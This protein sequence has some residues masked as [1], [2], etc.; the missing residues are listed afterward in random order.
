M[1]L[2]WVVS[3]HLDM[4]SLEQCSMV[5]NRFLRCTAY[6]VCGSY[7]HVRTCMYIC[8]CIEE[9][10]LITVLICMYMYMCIHCIGVQGILLSG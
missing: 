3:V 10:Q 4:R 5:S 8:I 6:T 7:V 2:Y 1:I 9:N